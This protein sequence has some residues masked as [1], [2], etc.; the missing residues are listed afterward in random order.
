[1]SD[2][3]HFSHKNDSGYDVNA[4]GYDKNGVFRGS[5]PF[6]NNDNNQTYTRKK[7]NPKAV[8]GG[9]LIGLIVIYFIITKILENLVSVIAIL[10]TVILCIIF[11]KVAKKKIAKKGLA[12]FLAII[13]SLGIITGIIYLGPVQNDGN[14]NKLDIT[15]KLNTANVMF[16]KYMDALEKNDIITLI[17]Y[18]TFVGNNIDDQLYSTYISKY[19][20]DFDPNKI[21]NISKQIKGN[22]ATFYVY[23]YGFGVN[24]STSRTF[25]MT[26]IKGKWKL[27]I[28]LK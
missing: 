11:C 2:D 25:N 1:M 4:Y 9:G 27:I 3:W 12:T 16:Q 17:E 6:K 22:N 15:L 28:Q 24:D 14:F 7:V 19:F 21:F 18:T 13:I 10:V 20:K 23:Y 5:S 26:K 8:G